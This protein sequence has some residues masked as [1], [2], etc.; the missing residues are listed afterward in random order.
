MTAGSS[1][2]MGTARARG[3]L[4]SA[5]GLAV[6]LGPAPAAHADPGADRKAEAMFREGRG[7]IERGDVAGGCA[8]LEAS[9]RLV[10]RASTVLNL[11]DCDE[12]QRRLTSAIAR[13][14]QGI[15]LL[16]ASD[17]RV[18]VA[19][20][21]LAGV[22]RRIP[23]VTL[24]IDPEVPA[25]A[26]VDLDGAPLARGEVEGDHPLDPGR[27]VIVVTAPGH[28]EVER[29][30]TLEEGERRPISLE[31]GP[32][33]PGAA[34]PQDDPGPSR[35]G[36]GLRAA[37]WAVGGIGVAGLA[38][39][40]VTGALTLD[41]KHL[42]DDNCTPTCN[43]ASREAATA[44]KAL[45]TASTITFVGGAALAATGLVLVLV[46]GSKGKPTSTTWTGGPVPG[47]SFVLMRSTF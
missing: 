22:R 9:L 44:G 8:R 26:R 33:E 37:G 13:W 24:R 20:E 41:K 5:I 38:V 42:V 10:R 2:E 16:P 40:L 43:D 35:P 14:Q 32:F 3:L 15:A 27:H 4:G 19:R 11:A 1:P 28:V 7:L 30:F 25:A 21:R 12:R 23:R 39:G 36:A 29:A 34:R 45:S 18:A 31:V 46:G 6:A 47:G 17:V